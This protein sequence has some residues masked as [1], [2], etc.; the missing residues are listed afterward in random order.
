MTACSIVTARNELK[1]PYEAPESSYNLERE[2]YQDDYSIARQELGLKDSLLDEGSMSSVANRVMLNRLERSLHSESEKRQYYLFKSSL[3]TDSQR[4]QF[5]QLP[6]LEEREKKA[7]SLGL[8]NQLTN[9]SPQEQAAIEGNDIFVGM[10]KRG[11]RESWGDPES[12]EVAGN[13]IYGNERWTYSAFVSTPEGFSQENRTI[14][15]ESGYVIGWQ[16]R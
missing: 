8:R 7:V 11:V 9:S 10:T 12:I 13:P 2:R 3:K 1:A 14:L 15:F 16:K 6:T 4:I 5:L